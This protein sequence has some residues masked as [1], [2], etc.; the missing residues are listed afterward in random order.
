VSSKPQGNEF[1]IER[2]GSDSSDA[3]LHESMLQNEEAA[4]IS[5]LAAVEAA[6]AAGIPFEMAVRHLAGD[7]ARAKLIAAGLLSE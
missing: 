6:I 1:R 4:A 7:V 5:D 2:A 3:A